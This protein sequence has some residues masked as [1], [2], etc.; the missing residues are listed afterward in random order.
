M[1]CDNAKTFSV[2][3]TTRYGPIEG[4]VDSETLTIVWKGIP[5]A[6]PPIGERRWKA[7]GDPQPWQQVLQTKGNIVP[8]AQLAYEPTWILLPE[9]RGSEDC[10]YLNVFRPQ[11]DEKDLPVFVWIH[12]GANHAGCAAEY[13]MENFARKSNTVVV[14]LQYRLNV[15]GF[16]THPA[17]RIGGS[18]E[19]RSGNYG[20][21][22]QLK[23]LQWVQENIGTFGGDPGNVTIAGESAGGHNISALLISPLANGLFHRAIM[24]SGLMVFESPDEA[25]AIAKRTIATAYAMKG[26]SK[27]SD[28]ASIRQYLL[29]LSTEE[30]VQAHAG[31]P[32]N[33]ALPLAN[34][35][36]DGYVVPGNLLCAFEAG[37][38]TKVPIMLGN[39]ANET[40][41]TSPLLPS[42]YDSMPD[43]RELN[44]VSYGKKALSD[45]LRTA[46][47]KELYAK[48]NFYGSLFWRTAHTDEISRRLSKHQDVY[49][50][51]FQWGDQK[52]RPG[53]L[54]FIYGAA[55]ALDIAFFHGNVDDE[56][57]C[58]A[59]QWA[60]YNGMTAENRAGRK[61]LSE[62]IIAYVANFVRS[63]TPNAEHSE[64]SQWLPWSNSDAGPKYMALG[65]DQ[66]EA[67]IEMQDDEH[68]M[69]GIW[70]MLD[71]EPAEDKEHILHVV[72]AFQSRY[73]TREGGVP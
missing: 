6:A 17:L 49:A 43:Y 10:L 23:A 16:F 47:D 50:Y 54:G 3:Q 7:P 19:D 25:D 62:A 36:E 33:T 66:K 52:S 2:K 27:Q 13:D 31:G 30:L 63:G 71:E 5:F 35:I 29:S 28:F 69:E 24:Q 42:L 40:G 53:D 46:K 70:E 37:R 26:K 38:Y 9:V 51:S 73:A 18:L 67:I 48:A 32:G 34:Q 41:L 45:V 56:E 21:L 22:D 1:S 44:D 68:S 60:I 58:A 11:S 57:S 12:G 20:A 55:H 64:L 59:L 8:C 72:E 61:E 4:Y 65:A 15:F 39:T 14:V